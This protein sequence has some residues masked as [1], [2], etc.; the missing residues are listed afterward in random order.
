MKQK[1]E[2]H[3]T[4]KTQSTD[5]FSRQFRA[6]VQALKAAVDRE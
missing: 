1:D 3:G 4:K 2:K 5:K 6:E